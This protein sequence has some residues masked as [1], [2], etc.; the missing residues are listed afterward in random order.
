MVLKH[1]LGQVIIDLTFL[2]IRRIHVLYSKHE[3]SPF[4][5][6]SSLITLVESKM[7]VES[8]FELLSRLPRISTSLFRQGKELKLRVYGAKVNAPIRPNG[9]KQ[10]STAIEGLPT[11]SK[12]GSFGLLPTVQRWR[13]QQDHQGKFPLLSTVQ[14]WRHQQEEEGRFHFAAPAAVVAT[15]TAAS[16]EEV[17]EEN[18]LFNTR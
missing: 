12:K 18:E 16:M 5:F 14:R 13:D 10:I 9:F 8:T 4:S 3:V 11:S 2:N 7:V 17:E 6:K 15:A 1:L